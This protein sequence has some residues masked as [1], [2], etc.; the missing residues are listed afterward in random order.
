MKK[1]LIATGVSIFIL[2]ACSKSS[3]NP[4]PP[5]GG[6]G[7]TLDCSTVST[8]AFAADVNPIIQTK[9]ATDGGCHGSGSTN[10]PGPLLD[11]AAI[12][13]ARA[14]IRTAV[15]TGEMPKTGS[16][17]TAQKNSILCWVDSGGPNN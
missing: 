15:A 4:T 5:P 8:K 16:I 10:G 9:C 12:F 17:T 1:E 11:Y 13:N 7:G 14:A 3:D 2:I 6:G